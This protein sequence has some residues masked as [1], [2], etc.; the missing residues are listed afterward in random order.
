MTWLSEDAGEN[1]SSRELAVYIYWIIY[2]SCCPQQLISPLEK[3]SWNP[4]KWHSRSI[5][6]IISHMFRTY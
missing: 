1:C 6:I 4:E 5:F 3:F 2:F